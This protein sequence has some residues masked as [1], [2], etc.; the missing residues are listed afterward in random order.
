MA[1]FEFR[2]PHMQNNCKESIAEFIQFKF[3]RVGVRRKG[4]KIR[5][6]DLGCLKRQNRNLIGF[7]VG[8]LIQKTVLPKLS[9]S[10]A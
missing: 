5:T 9:N 7:F 6:L 3:S 8:S 4:V 2:D 1:L 10:F